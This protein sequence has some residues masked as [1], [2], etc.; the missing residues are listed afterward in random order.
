[1]SGP[2]IEGHADLAHLRLD[3]L[4]HHRHFGAVDR[5]E[6]R[7][8]E[9]VRAV[10]HHPVGVR[11]PSCLG[12]EAAG[13]GDVMAERRQSR[14]VPTGEHGRQQ[15]RRG[16]GGIAKHGA[17][18]AG[19]VDCERE[20]LPHPEIGE[21]RQ[22]QV[23]GQHAGPRDGG[24]QDRGAAAGLDALRRLRQQ[25]EGQVGLAGLGQGGARLAERGRGVAD[26]RDG[27]AGAPVVGEGLGLDHL[28]AL[29]RGDPVGAGRDRLH[30]LVG[31]VVGR[32]GQD[33]AGVVRHER[34]QRRKRRTGAQNEFAVAVG[35]DG[36]EGDR[37]KGFCFGL[38]PLQ[39]GRGDG[40]GQPCAVV[41]RRLAQA[42]P[43]GQAIGVYRP[44]FGQLAHQLAAGFGRDQRLA[45]AHSDEDVAGIKRV[46]RVVGPGRNH[47]EHTLLG[48][49]T[50]RTEHGSE[51]R[52]CRKHQPARQCW[53]GVQACH[54]AGP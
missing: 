27:R 53:G 25:G 39:R 10:R 17:G 28:R 43:P 34:G 50:V 46:R 32:R 14:V 23:H 44:A 48:P 31:R 19:A 12:Q 15:L 13:L 8:R 2:H 47:A 45:N 38:H 51:E 24:A 20:G 21:L 41:E 22:G 35:L 40:G 16:A 49:G 26:A 29:Q 1:M 18:D 3:G 52:R 5:H 36:G 7:R 42:E 11:R 6:Q 4:R 37:G 54:S 30:G 9:A 33:N